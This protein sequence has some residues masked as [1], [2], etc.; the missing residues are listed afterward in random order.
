[1]ICLER[2]D[3]LLMV[4][5]DGSGVAISEA[6]FAEPGLILSRNLLDKRP[7]RLALSFISAD[8]SYAPGAV[9]ARSDLGEVGYSVQAALPLVLSEGVA[10]ALAERLLAAALEPETAELALGPDALALEAGDRL[11]LADSEPDWQVHEVGDD[12]LVRRLTLTRP[13]GGAPLLAISPPRLA[14]DVAAGAVP[15]LVLIDG[16]PLPGLGGAG[17]LA[18]VS[19]DPW[20]GPQVIMAGTLAG[21]MTRRGEALSPA[22]IGRL[23]EPL[24]AGPLGRWDRASALVI[25]M[26]EAGLSGVDRLAA[27][28]GASLVLIEGEDGWELIGFEAAELEGAGRWRLTG[29]LRGLQGSAP[30]AAAEGATAVIVDDALV[31]TAFARNETGLVLSWQAGAGE[32]Q[33]F[34]HADRAGLPWP[35]AHLRGRKGEGESTV[36]SWLPRGPGI[37]DNWDLPDPVVQRRFRVEAVADGAVAWQIETGAETATI[38]VGHDLARVAE[39]GADGRMGRWVS[40][41]AGAS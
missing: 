19:A 22:R 4:P 26:A 2:E 21:Y 16:P 15:E 23:A 24:A 10:S 38:P 18:A 11:A 37:P 40:I 30:A 17:P 14:P 39:I 33:S 41:M 35:V 34:V 9:D 1:M 28:A 29:L 6:R 13:A 27:L 7:G 36:L 31:A 20:G 5:G 8:G 25:D 32:L 12:G 3:G